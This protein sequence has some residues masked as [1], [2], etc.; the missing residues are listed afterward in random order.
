M[1]AWKN[2][3]PNRTVLREMKRET[4]L[5]EAAS[6]FNRQGFHAT[7][8]DEIARNLGV[9]KAALYYYFPNKNK[10]L[11]ACFEQAMEAAFRHL[12]KAKKEGRNGRQ[13]VIGALHG[14]LAEMIDELSC[15]VLLTEENALKPKERAA[16]IAER[17]AYEN[18]LRELVRE[19]IQDGSILRCDPKLA[20]F[21]MLGAMNWVP[22]WFSHDGPWESGQLAQ[23]L[24]D[25]LDRMLSAQ[26]C[27]KL[28]GD[29]ADVRLDRGENGQQYDARHRA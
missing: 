11:H 28:V 22:K 26:P 16:L 23:A 24:T 9:T 19:G 5:R 8:L 25:M 1:A 21:T 20:V 10:L 12:E 14:Y 27:E 6:A 13:K 4:L 2:L 18:A 17:D 3:V 7:S 29:V 15:C